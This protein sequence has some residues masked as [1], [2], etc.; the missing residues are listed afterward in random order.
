M[1]DARETVVL[2]DEHD[3]EVGL[4]PKLD[5]HVS[6]ALHRA[7]S[8]FVLN[9]RGEVLLQRRADGKY[10]CGGL[11]TNTCC[12]HPRPGEP[13]AAAARRRLREEMGFDCVL[14]SAGAFVYRADVGGGLREHEYDHVFIGRHDLA[15]APDAEEASDWRWQSPDSALA[16]AEAHPERFTPWFALALRKL[17]ERRGGDLAA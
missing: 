13:V 14:A 8:V 5:A 12:G 7:F 2:V 4:A 17:I 10:H 16:E 1:V 6:G 3:R 9:A 11:W 15:P